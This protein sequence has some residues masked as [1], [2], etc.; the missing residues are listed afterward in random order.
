[1]HVAQAKFR[2]RHQIDIPVNTA[3]AEHILVF[4][5][6]AVT[7]AIHFDCQYVFTRLHIL[8]NVEL[9][10]V[11]G[12]LAIPDFL[13][14]DPQIHSAVHSVEVD[15]HFFIL[16]VGRQREFPPIGTYRIRLFLYRI[17]SLS[18][19]KGRI[20]AYRIGDIGIDGGS[21]SQHLPIGRNRNLFP[22]RHVIARFI[23]IHRT[24]GR[25][26]HP[27]KLPVTIQQQITGRLIAYP[28]TGVRRIALHLFRIG[29]GDK[30][31]TPLFFVNGKYP[32]ILPVII[33]PGFKSLS[34][35]FQIRFH[36]FPLLAYFLRIRFELVNRLGHKT[37]I[38]ETQVITTRY[39]GEQ[40]IPIG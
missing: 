32:F 34:H 14:I 23:E 31:R 3:Q 36:D 12:T 5:I 1:M 10:I 33:T 9:G 11:V 6:A 39:T 18:L 28:R 24:F 26:L 37:G 27:M 21:V 38:R 40:I 13:T 17:S 15:K 4:Q 22:G 19:Y 25:L 2:S 8:C 35:H 29:K 20:V 7:P 30:R 16:P